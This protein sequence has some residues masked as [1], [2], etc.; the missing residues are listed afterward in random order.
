MTGWETGKSERSL[1][2]VD[3]SVV[4]FLYIDDSAWHM[5][6]LACLW[7]SF[8]QPFISHSCSAMTQEAV[9]INILNLSKYCF[10]F[11]LFCMITTNLCEVVTFSD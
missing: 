7:A 4:H 2:Y 5:R 8:I 1:F 10:F 11:F 6:V 9:R 3:P